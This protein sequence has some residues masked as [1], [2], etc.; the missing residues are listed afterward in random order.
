LP[1][2]SPTDSDELVDR[3]RK[4]AGDKSA[5]KSRDYHHGKKKNR[6][7]GHLPSKAKE[8]MKQR[9]D[10]EHVREINLVTILAEQ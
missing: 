6:G 1:R 4:G 7:S 3:F 10:H 9:E 8:K 5:E 2:T